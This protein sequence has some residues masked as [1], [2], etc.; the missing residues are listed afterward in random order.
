MC[1]VEV[2]VQQGRIR[3]LWCG[4]L[5]RNKSASKSASETG[6]GTEIAIMTHLR[7]S[8]VTAAGHLLCPGRKESSG[9]RIAAA[10]PRLVQNTINRE[11]A[12]E[13]TALLCRPG[14]AWGE[15]IALISS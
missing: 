3:E 13:G 10:A 15:G 11:E 8:A 9:A 7:G 6:T 14:A 5:P 1:T 4:H 2:V 12:E